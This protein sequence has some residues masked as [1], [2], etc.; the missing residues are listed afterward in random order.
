MNLRREGLQHLTQWMLSCLGQLATPL[1]FDECV[2]VLE[3]RARHL[4]KCG[5]LGLQRLPRRCCLHLGWATSIHRK[6]EA[7]RPVGA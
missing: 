1:R 3:E 6:L 5:T 7:G 2:D 4:D